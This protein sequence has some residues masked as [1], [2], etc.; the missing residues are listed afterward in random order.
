[1][2]QLEIPFEFKKEENKAIFGSNNNGYDCQNWITLDDVNSLRRH[3]KH[4]LVFNYKTK[5][6]F[7]DGMNTKILSSDT[8]NIKP[9][10]CAYL[11]F[12]RCLRE[13]GYRFN[14]KL[15]TIEKIPK[16]VG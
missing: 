2:K 15:S 3:V 8:I 14:K 12:E 5:R 9:S 6:L 13:N 7:L 11:I 4:I 10:I 16:R 1:M